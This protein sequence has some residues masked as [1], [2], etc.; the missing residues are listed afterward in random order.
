MTKP[1]EMTVK[2]FNDSIKDLMIR[3]VKVKDIIEKIRSEMLSKIEV[4]GRNF[5]LV[6]IFAYHV[7]KLILNT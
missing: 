2:E 6:K 1:N 7:S 5:Y 3:P 4:P